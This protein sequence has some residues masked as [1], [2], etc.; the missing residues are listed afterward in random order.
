MRVLD[1]YFRHEAPRL[2]ASATKQLMVKQCGQ[3]KDLGTFI[4]EFKLL[5]AQAMGGQ[6][7]GEVI[8]IQL[9]L[10]Q[11]RKFSELG[12]TIA[13]WE[14]E[15]EDDLVEGAS[16]RLVRAVDRFVADRRLFSEE[17]AP[18]H[19]AHI[20][21]D[22]AME[23]SDQRPCFRC[24]KVGHWVNKCPQP[25]PREKGS[26]SVKGKGKGGQGKGK[27]GRK[28]KSG[29]SAK[30]SVSA[31]R[32]GKGKH[33]KASVAY[34][35]AD[36]GGCWDEDVYVEEEDYLG[37]Y[38]TGASYSAVSSSVAGRRVLPDVDHG[39]AQAH[40]KPPT[41]EQLQAWYASQMQ[42]RPSV[43]GTAAKGHRD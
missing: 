5:E 23:V 40:Q 2:Q 11:F 16:E 6:Q 25:D 7:L 24:G 33:T 22:V 43:K 1:E 18:K 41:V 4:A 9:L 35:Y 38:N 20:A 30:G 34:T 42:A 3:L 15:R 26:S 29:K 13:I 31:L 8:R 28:G 36:D 32:K 39:D 14:H 12:A 17:K 27:P 37:P 10:T 19:K 21:A